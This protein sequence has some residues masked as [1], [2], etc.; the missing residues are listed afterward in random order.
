VAPGQSVTQLQ[1]FLQLT[2][3]GSV[4]VAPAVAGVRSTPA[5]VRSTPVAVVP[6]DPVAVVPVDPVAVV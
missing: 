2:L 6:V 5:V 4:S 1:H 3:V